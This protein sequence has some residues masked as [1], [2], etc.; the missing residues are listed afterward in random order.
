MVFDWRCPSVCS[1]SARDLGSFTF[2]GPKLAVCWVL[3]HLV[4]LQGK[5]KWMVASRASVCFAHMVKIWWKRTS[6]VAKTENNTQQLFF[7]W[8]LHIHRIFEYLLH[9]FCCS[10]TVVH[11]EAHTFKPLKHMYKHSGHL[12]PFSAT[13]SNWEALCDVF[14]SIF[15]C[16]TERKERINPH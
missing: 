10:T 7:S 4:S 2:L 8:W 12:L 15:R 3:W 11:P 5:A 1:N 6:S 13:D 9:F 16:L 14:F